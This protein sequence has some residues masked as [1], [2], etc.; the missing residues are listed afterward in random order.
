M[1]LV[2]KIYTLVVLSFAMASQS[3][4]AGNVYFQSELEK[5]KDGSVYTFVSQKISLDDG[6]QS[7]IIQFSQCTAQYNANQ[8]SDKIIK[9]NAIGE[10]SG[11]FL[12]DLKSRDSKLLAIGIIEKVGTTGVLVVGAFNAGTY[13]V[14]MCAFG[15]GS[16]A[17]TANALSAFSLASLGSTVSNFIFDWTPSGS[18]RASKT[19]SG[20]KDFYMHD[21]IVKGSI[22][23]VDSYLKYLTMSLS[24]IKSV[25][26]SN[27]LVSNK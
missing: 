24:Q 21:T 1:K 4:L 11:Y 6:T 17:L 22:K 9:C 10:P 19:I 15:C 25:S 13:V 7:P 26:W 14:A 2:T 12:S 3:A 20:S 18:L 5:R 8:G 23:E 27:R 16:A